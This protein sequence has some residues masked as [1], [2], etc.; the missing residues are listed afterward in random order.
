MWKS[1]RRGDEGTEEGGDATGEVMLK[2]K[3]VGRS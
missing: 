3:R 1:D 2:D